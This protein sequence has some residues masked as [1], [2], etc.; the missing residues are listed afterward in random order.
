MTQAAYPSVANEARFVDIVLANVQ[1]SECGVDARLIESATTM[2]D[3]SHPQFFQAIH[4]VN[5]GPFDARL[6]LF[7]PARSWIA[8]DDCVA[9]DC[10][11]PKHI[12]IHD[13][14]GSLTGVPSTV[15]GR[16]EFMNE[17]RAD[18]TTETNYRVPA[19]MINDPA[20][21][22][23]R[24]PAM[25]KPP[26]TQS[27]AACEP[28]W[29]LNDGA[30]RSS[31]DMDE[32]AVAHKGYGMYRENCTLETAWNAWWCASS[33]SQYMRLVIESMDADTESRSLVPVALAFGGYVD[34]LNGGQDHGWCFGYTCLKR[35]S[36]FYSTVAVGR[37]YDLSFTGTNPQSLRLMMP[38][39]SEEL[40]NGKSPEPAAEPPTETPGADG[41]AA[42]ST[43]VSRSRLNQIE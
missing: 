21:V 31:P 35:L 4:L 23:S 10:D 37:P 13:L 16:A 29:A 38:S 33:I 41:T 1:P 6:R 40:A 34:L 42:K 43:P 11:G 24:A 14:D 15:H 7:E 32:S 2:S 18:G 20:P 25:Q 27:Q 8:I 3:A 36:T 17:F 22:S 30:C 5:P 39:A 28:A 26:S 19:K 9:M 12:L